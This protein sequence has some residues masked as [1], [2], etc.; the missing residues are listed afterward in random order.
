[1][2]NIFNS[3]STIQN[4]LKKKKQDIYNSPISSVYKQPTIEK[5]APRSYMGIPT[6]GSPSAPPVDKTQPPPTATSNYQKMYQDYLNRSQAQRNMLAQQQRDED[7]RVAQENYDLT[8]KSLQASRA[9][10]DNLLSGIRSRSSASSARLNT[11]AEANKENARVESGANQ[12]KLMEDRRQLQAQKEK[13]YAA[14]GTIDSY[15]T[16]SFQSA[17]ENIDNDFLRMTNENKRLLERNLFDIDQKL[18]DAKAN[19][20]EQLATEESK[21]NDAIIQIENA[22]GLNDAQRNQL[23]RGAQMKYQTAQADIFDQYENLRLT[24]EKEKADAQ[25]K[26]DQASQDEQKLMDVMK[27]ASPAFLQTGVPQT[28]QD[29]FIIMKYPKEAEAYAKMIKEGQASAGSKNKDTA[30]SMVNRLLE[31]DTSS[32]TGA[33]RTGGVPVLSSLRG[34]AIQQADYNGL[35]ALLALAERGQL[36]GTGAVSDFEA[37]MLEKAAMAGL[38]QDLPDHEFRRRLEILRNDLMSGGAV[39]SEVIQG[40]LITAPDGKLI[41]IID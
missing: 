32:I 25:A 8:N 13:Q 9:N 38:T 36:K 18:L 7:M 19:I 29:Q 14:L 22:Q 40:N 37:K 16:G 21:Y 3:I 35:K 12:R 23:V 28:A 4:A 11:Q 30:L 26:L 15:G 17:N 41:Q 6:T 2:F 24:A 33:L 5:G 1:M 20:E 10:L 27:T 34:S 31:Q 39:S